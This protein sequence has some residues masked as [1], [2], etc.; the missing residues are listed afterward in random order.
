LPAYTSGSRI[1]TSLMTNGSTDLQPSD[2]QRYYDEWTEK[3]LEFFGESIQAHRP[4]SEDELLNYLMTQAG[5][6]D[7]QH[8]LDAGCGICGPARHFAKNRSITI[9]A[10]TISPVQEKIARAR[11]EAAGLADRIHVTL[12]DYHQLV[13]LYGRERFDAVYFLESLSHSSR[14]AEVVSGA[15]EVLK[16]GG[17]IYIKDYF[18]LKCENAEEQARVLEVIA[19]IDSTFSV[20]SPWPA[21]IQA[22]LRRAGFLPLFMNKP[23]FEA[24]N[25]IWQLFAGKHAFN[26]YDGKDSFECWEYL[27]MKS[28]KP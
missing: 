2:V 12:G 8:V 21:E 15:Y 14:P 24:D 10:V 18:I 19:R 25:T 6:R 4:S 11:N 5:L 7:G 13:K 22:E 23:R 9:E 17:I 20:K 3:Y 26:V 28:Q 27:E 1:A 16:P